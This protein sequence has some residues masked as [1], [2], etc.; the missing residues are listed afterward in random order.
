MK[1]KLSFS[2]EWVGGIC[3]RHFGIGADGLMIIRPS[4]KADFSM[5]FF[6]PDGSRAEMCGNGIRCFAKYLYDHGLTKKRKVSIETMAGIKQVALIVDSGRATG[7]SVD[8]GVPSFRPSDMPMK[9]KKEAIGKLL[10]INR[11]KF[12]VTCLSVGNPHCVIFVEEVSD[13]PVRTLGPVVE[14]WPIFPQKT[15]VEFAEV[16]NPTEM[17]VRVWERGAGETLACGTGACAALVAAARNGLTK[18]GA[19]IHLPGGDLHVEWSEDDHIYLTG[20]AEEVF[21][22]EIPQTGPKKLEEE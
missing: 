1:N 16:V 15:N 18:R 10:E 5:I 6:N 20:P 13:A 3:D 9:S 17:R 12:R 21:T 22:G 2:S 19:T 8:M 11:E 14:N 7:A 4:Q